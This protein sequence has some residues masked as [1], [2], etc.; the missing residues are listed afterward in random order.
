MMLW[1]SRPVTRRLKRG[2][3]YRTFPGRRRR[4][5]MIGR[6]ARSLRG[7]VVAS[8]REFVPRPGFSQYSADC[9]VEVT[10]SLS[11]CLSLRHQLFRQC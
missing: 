9:P 5:S 10:T 3:A 4:Q 11:F 6:T 2:A 7:P 8:N 1:E